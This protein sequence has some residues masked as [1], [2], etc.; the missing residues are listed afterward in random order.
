MSD[1][2][3]QPAAPPAGNPIVARFAPLLAVVGLCWALFVINNLLWHN[4]LNQYGIVP[5]HLRGLVGILPA[6]FLHASFGHLL[7]NTVPLLLLGGVICW[8]SKSEFWEVTIAGILLGG[9]L[10]WLF[11]RNAT[12]I[13]ASGLIFCFFGYLAS[14]AYFRRTFG[15]LLV[16]VMCV[17]VYG[18]MVK[19]IIPT[20]TPIS[21]ESHCAGL[22]AGITLA[23]AASKRDP[24]PV[25]APVR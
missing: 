24:I 20:A 1:S 8:R 22:L 23:W 5:R 25:A 15:T 6:P 14:L 3:P 7:G 10:T 18:G 13:G 12:H 21:W 9:G 2:M 17:F 16:S 19:G 11:A 4:H